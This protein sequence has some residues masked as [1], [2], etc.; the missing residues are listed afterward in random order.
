[1]LQG[2][3]VVPALAAAY[4]VAAP[5]PLRRR[6]AHLVAGAA[7]MIVAAGWWVALVELWPAGSRPYIGGSNSQLDPGA[8]LRLQRHRPAHRQ[9]Q[10]RQR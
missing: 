3:L 1:M 7:A 9:Q 10:Q 8:D 4:L 6:V 2:F 5:T